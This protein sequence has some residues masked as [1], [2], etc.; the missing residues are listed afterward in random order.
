MQPAKAA[1][2]QCEA[3]GD[4]RAILSGQLCIVEGY[5]T[6]ACAWQ[7][8]QMVFHRG[9][10]CVDVMNVER[11]GALCSYFCIVDVR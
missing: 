7:P 4:C 1:D 2:R 3:G 11:Q 6:A 8:P 5:C 9:G 10:H